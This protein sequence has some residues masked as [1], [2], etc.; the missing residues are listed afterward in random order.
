LVL[1]EKAQ[2]DPYIT[3]DALDYKAHFRFMRKLKDFKCALWSKKYG[4][5][6]ILQ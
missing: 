6:A 2:S 4:N 1:D 5:F 3:G